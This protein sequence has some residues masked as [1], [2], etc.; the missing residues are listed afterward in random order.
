MAVLPNGPMEIC[1][2]FDTTGSMSS[3]ITEVKGRVQDMIQ[4]LQ[5]DIPG[6]RIAVFAHGDYC[7]RN[8]S[9]V[10]KHI[11]FSTNVAD[12]CKWVK[13]VGSTGGGDA[14]ECYELVLHEVQGLSWTP[15][16]QRAL[17]MIGDANPHEPNYPQ[18]TKN[19]DWRKE[20]DTL[21]TMVISSG[22]FFYINMI[23]RIEQKLFITF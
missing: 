18:N 5:A 17:V 2:S 20:T 1:F 14:D 11:D 21:A 9:Y 22:F 3:S 13:E 16:S 7:D 4:R 8:S 12:I 23:N 6:I 19:L 15:G 10:T